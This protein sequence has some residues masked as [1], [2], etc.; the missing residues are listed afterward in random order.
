MTVYNKTLNKKDIVKFM[1]ENQGTDW[2]DDFYKSMYNLRTMTL[3]TEDLWKL[4]TDTDAKL[5]NK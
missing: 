5:F 4:V 3:I 1:E 2:Y